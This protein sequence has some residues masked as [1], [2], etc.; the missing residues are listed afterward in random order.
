MLCHS[1][2]FSEIP[3]GMWWQCIP[4]IYDHWFCAQKLLFKYCSYSVLLLLFSA[5]SFLYTPEHTY[6]L[7]VHVATSVLPISL[8]TLTTKLF[9]FLFLFYFTLIAF[10][11]TFLGVFLSYLPSA[12][13][14]FYECGTAAGCLLI[15]LSTSPAPQT[16]SS[17]R[18][19]APLLM[20]TNS[21]STRGRGVSKHPLSSY[22]QRLALY[23]KPVESV[24]K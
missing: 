6:V 7:H 10:S 8:G 24:H 9:F 5:H 13:F 12:A 17:P 21:S 14:H 2:L 22:K 16:V 23:R 1:F 11:S 19:L 3:V 20:E 15:T 4:S 18:G